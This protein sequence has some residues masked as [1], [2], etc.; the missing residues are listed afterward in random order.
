MDECNDSS[1]ESDEDINFSQLAKEENLN[2]IDILHRL[3]HDNKNILKQKK[4][5]IKQD[6]YI[7]KK[8]NSKKIINDINCING[9]LLTLSKIVENT[10]NY[11]QEF[12]INKMF[13]ICS[14]FLVYLHSLLPIYKMTNKRVL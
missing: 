6:L 13:E 10:Q 12:F 4:K 8:N 2:N 9:F 11:F 7:Y 1:S 3:G 14:S 5:K